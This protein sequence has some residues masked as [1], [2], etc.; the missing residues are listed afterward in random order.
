M[1]IDKFKNINDNYGHVVGDIVLKKIME[2]CKELLGEKYY[3]ER[4]RESNL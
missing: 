1:D 4:Y 3:I 2:V